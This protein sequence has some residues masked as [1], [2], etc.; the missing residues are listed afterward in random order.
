MSIRTRF[1]NRLWPRRLARELQDEVE[2]HIAMRVSEHLKAGMS[3]DEAIKEARQQFGDIEVVV[4]DMRKER[5]TSMT[6][7]LTVT[8]LLTV[9]A[10]LW[11]AQQRISSTD[12][13]MPAV[14]AVTIFKDPNLLSSSSPPPRPAPGPTWEQFVKQTKAFDALRT[15]PGVY[16]PGRL[17]DDEGRLIDDKVKSR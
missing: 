3:P 2:F 16:S 12:S 9:V 7:V 4:A 11:V 6:V 14:R 8:A 17:I 13:R 1:V 15:G 10:M 5:L